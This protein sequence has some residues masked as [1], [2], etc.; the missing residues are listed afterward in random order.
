MNLSRRDLNKLL[1]GCLT[2]PAFP[3]FLPGQAKKPDSKVK[4]VQIGVQT[5]S[6]RDRS[7]DEA[8]K[9]M[10]EVGL[11]S[12]ELWQGHVEPRDQATRGPQG[13]DAL[14]NWRLTVPLDEIK[15][16]RAKFDSAGIELY[17]YNLSFRDDFTDAEMDRGFEIA[18]ALGVKIITASSNVSTAKRIDGFARKHKIRVGMHNHSKVSDP[19]EFATPESFARAMEGNS[20][21]I[22]INLDIG[23]FTAAN[24]DAVDFLRRHHDRIVTLHIKDRKKDQGDNVP[25]GEG[26]TPIKAVLALLREQKW[27]IPANVEYEYKGSDT[28]QEVKRCLEYCRRAL[29][30]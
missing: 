17:A 13:R 23:H 2:V 10:V 6:F 28:V 20:E 4:G 25:F 22:A 29:E 16:V 26:D 15:A 24:F 1:A 3:D 21:Y 9:A 8:I 7:L 18:K 27:N 11:S 12:C 19:N 30:T 5:Y 14:R